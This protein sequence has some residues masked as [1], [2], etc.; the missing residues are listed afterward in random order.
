MQIFVTSRDPKLS[1]LRLYSQT[2]RALKMITETQQILAAVID[3]HGWEHKL[4]K[5]DG[6]PYKSPKSRIN[7]PVVV[8]A[9]GRDSHMSWLIDHLEALYVLYDGDKFKNVQK[10]IDI[11]RQFY[12][13]EYSSEDI[14]FLNFAKADDKGLDFRHIDNV[15]EAYDQFL[16]IQ[17]EEVYRTK[18]PTFKCEELDEY[19]YLDT[20]DRY[21]T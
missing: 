5:V 15:F 4:L 20:W 18:R 17:S 11:L 9:R 7:H 8:W 3:V 16:E 19:C 13:A 12:Y 21:E 10:N 1:A 2:N 6:K 14:T